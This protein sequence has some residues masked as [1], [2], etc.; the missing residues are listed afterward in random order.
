[1]IRGDNDGGMLIS[2][3]VSLDPV[4]VYEGDSECEVLV[5]QISL[6]QKDLR[7]IAG[8]GPQ[9]CAPVIVRETYRN[10]VEEQVVRANLAGTSVIIAED[11]NAKLG[12]S[13]IK[14]DPNPMSENGKLLANMINFKCI[15]NIGNMNFQY[16][17]A[18]SITVFSFFFLSCIFV[19]VSF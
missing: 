1:M 16:F 11:A 8:Y 10:T 17:P 12:P 13:W 15:C 3:L 14:N 6:K 9:E 18:P 19:T 7:I 2:C 4:L 5:V